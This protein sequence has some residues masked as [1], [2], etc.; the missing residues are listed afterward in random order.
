MSKTIVAIGGE[1]VGPEVMDVTLDILS[2]LD[3]GFEI[4]TPP[5]GETAQKELG[6]PFPEETKHQCD[7]ADAVLFGAIGRVSIPILVY[8]RWAMDNFIN[9]RPMK[10]YPGANSPL[11]DPEGT[12]FV[13]LRENSE[14]L[15]PWGREGEIAELAARWP[16]WRDKCLGKSFADYG[17]G[18]FAIRIITHGGCKRLMDFAC[19]FT[20]DRKDRGYPGK[21]TCVT[22]SNVLHDSCGIFQG[23]AEEAIKGYPELAYEHFYIDDMARRVIR[24]PRNQDVIVTSN[25][26]GDILADAAAEAVGGLGIAPSACLGG[27]IPFFEPVHGSAPDIAGQGK[28]NP[29]AMILSAAMMLDHLGLSDRAKI[30]DEAVAAVYREGRCLTP[31]Q[32]GTATTNEMAQAIASKL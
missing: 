26:F 13:I 4:L 20:K 5:A 24:F 12:D 16:E 11:K 1:G 22:K 32:G 14:G 30:L 19:R 3:T 25:M 7:K 10:Y 8:M 31:D 18:V 27:R 15:Y 2:K 6:D 9:I 28:V 21:L 23:A 29:T 17:R